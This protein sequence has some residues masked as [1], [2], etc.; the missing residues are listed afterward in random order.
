MATPTT[1]PMRALLGGIGARDPGEQRTDDRAQH[2]HHEDGHGDDP[3]L[4][5]FA[6]EEE[7]RHRKTEDA[8]DQ[9][10]EDRGPPLS[11]NAC[12]RHVPPLHVGR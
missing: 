1:A 8:E 9:E 2:G 3:V 12:G 7:G 11:G 6:V 4:A 10:D 5:A